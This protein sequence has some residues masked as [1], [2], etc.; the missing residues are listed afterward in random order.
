[1]EKKGELDKSPIRSPLKKR[2]MDTRIDPVPKHVPKVGGSRLSREPREPKEPTP[3][4]S[5]PLPE[6]KPRSSF[7]LKKDPTAPSFK[8]PQLEVIKERP[9][10]SPIKFIDGNKKPEGPKEKKPPSKYVQEIIR[11]GFVELIHKYDIH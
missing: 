2:D 11:R 10:F 8:M 3:K 7:K 6:P 4:Q 5:K 9:R 1:M